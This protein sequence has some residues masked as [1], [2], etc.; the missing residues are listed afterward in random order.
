M[1][2]VMDSAGGI[3]NLTQDVYVGPSELARTNVGEFVQQLEDY[4]VLNLNTSVSQL[5][6]VIT[7][8]TLELRYEN[9]TDV[10]DPAVLRLKVG[11]VK[12]LFEVRDRIAVESYLSTQS[13]KLLS[14]LL[15][16]AD[17]LFDDLPESEQLQFMEQVGEVVTSAEEQLKRIPMIGRTQQQT[18]LADKYDKMLV[19]A[20]GVMDGIMGGVSVEANEQRRRRLRARRRGLEA[21]EQAENVG[22]KRGFSQEMKVLNSVSMSVMA[23]ITS[24]LKRNSLPNEEG[25]ANLGKNSKVQ[26]QVI[27]QKEMNRYLGQGDDRDWSKEIVQ[28]QAGSATAAEVPENEATTPAEPTVP[29]FDVSF[30]VL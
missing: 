29:I 15:E 25:K 2:S 3:T 27:T 11:L 20:M 6:G 18:L 13:Q 30:K 9:L 24:I 14:I 12:K 16:S 4:F 22:S 23:R 1:G 8:V 28:K 21:E 26:S 10:N 5:I 7:V 19:N 17:V